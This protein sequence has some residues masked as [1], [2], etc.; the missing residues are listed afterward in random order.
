MYVKVCGLRAADNI[1]AVEAAGTDWFGFIFYE[2]SPRY[3]SER[4][5]YL[6]VR[7]LRTG[8]FVSPA[9]DEVC[10][11]AEEFGLHAV[12]LHGRCPVALCQRLRADGLRVIRALP[13]CPDLDEA[14]SEYIGAC[15][16]FLFD[17]PSAA[18][19]GSGQTF[20]WSLLDTYTRD[21][22]FL[23]SGGLSPDSLHALSRWSHPSWAGIDLNSGF[24][25][26]PG[27]KN[28]R[29]LHTFISTFKSLSL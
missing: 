19:G 5:A 15:D 1:R 12:Q 21:V 20:D 17:T 7:G 3:V 11:R 27:L 23:L 6:P 18:Y 13:A 9:Y 29:A 24:E 28:A 22:P 14:A 8:V 4:P 2:H 25:T 26:A 10:R 16:F